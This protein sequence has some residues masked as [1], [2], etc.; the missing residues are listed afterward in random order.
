MTKQG[1]ITNDEGVR[2]LEKLRAAIPWLTHV[3][4]HCEVNSTQDRAREASA[5][6]LL[7]EALLVLADSQTAGR[8]RGNNHWWTG[9]GALATSLLFD[10]SFFGLPRRAIPQVSLATGVAVVDAIGPLVSG[11]VLGLRWPNDVYVSKR[12]LAGILVDVLPDGRHIIGVGINTNNSLDDAPPELRETVATLHWLTG[13][14][15][16]HGELLEIVLEQLGSGLTALARDPETIGRRFNELCLQY[17]E[18]LTVRNGDEYTTGRC[19]GIAVDGALL[20]D[21]P[22]GRKSIYSGTLRN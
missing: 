21:T 16:S 6:V 10:P 18:V 22:E 9:E 13:R 14:V 3:E 4:H 20:L 15:W 5:K 11:H 8:G 2:S 7:G 19:A 1:R 12:K 17:G